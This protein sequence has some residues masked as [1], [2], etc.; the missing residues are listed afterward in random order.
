MVRGPTLALALAAPR[1]VL[2]PVAPVR[3]VLPSLRV[4][5]A[6]VLAHPRRPWPSVQ[7]AP[8]GQHWRGRLGADTGAGG[9]AERARLPPPALARREEPAHLQTTNRKP[10]SANTA[11]YMANRMRTRRNYAVKTR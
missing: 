6:F 11:E 4:A 10:T 9:V 3:R 2:P 5:A 8:R 7:R 1:P